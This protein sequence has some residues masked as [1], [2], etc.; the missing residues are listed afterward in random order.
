LKQYFPSL[1]NEE[2][3]KLMSISEYKTFA[4]KEMILKSGNHQKKVFLILEGSV[5][6][7]IYDESGNINN[8]LLR[9]QGIFVGDAEAVFGGQAQKLNLEAMDR[10]SVIMFSIPDFEKLAKKYEGIRDL[11]I[12][13]MKEAILTLTYRLNTLITMTAEE[14]YLDLLNRNPFFLKDA[15]DKYVANYLGITPV[16][17]SRIKKKLNHR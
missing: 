3:S 16:T 2:Y 1:T 14:R 4:A 9:S 6:G 13:S 5:R 7:Y 11:Y 12:E 8:T 15:F 17:F 10:T